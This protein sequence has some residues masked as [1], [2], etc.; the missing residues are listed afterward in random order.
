LHP[1][2]NWGDVPLGSTFSSWYWGHGRAG[3]YSVVWF[4]L[5]T[6]NG[7][8]YRS[9]YVAHC[10]KILNAACDGIKVRPFG[11]NSS[12]PPTPT[13]GSP[14]GYD[15]ELLVGPDI[16]TAKA[17]VTHEFLNAPGLIQRWIGSFE[18]LGYKG[19]ALF[20]QFAITH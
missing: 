6:V 18:I 13:T 16:T 17:T 11:A 20:E 12:Y 7:T 9:S 5:L 14:S 19:T 10:G 15:I 1:I 4:D 2:Q 3:P 8:E